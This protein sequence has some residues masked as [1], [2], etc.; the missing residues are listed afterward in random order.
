MGIL[1]KD[2]NGNIVRFIQA[3]LA[4]MQTL[5]NKFVSFTTAKKEELK[6]NAQIIYLTK[7]LNDLYDNENRRIYISNVQSIVTVY[8]YSSTERDEPYIYSIRETSDAVYVPSVFESGIDY[9]YIIFVPAG[10]EYSEDKFNATVRRY[11]LADK[12]YI[13]QTY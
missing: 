10:L 13:I 5:N 9:N 11:N 7:R 3:C 2:G 8:V 1:V 4:G 6:Y 12:R